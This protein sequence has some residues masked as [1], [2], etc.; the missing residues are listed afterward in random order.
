R[1]LHGYTLTKKTTFREVCYA[2]RDSAFV[3]SDLPA[4][5]SLEVH[6]S[7]EQHETM[8]EIMTEAWK[9]LLVELTPEQ[10]ADLESGNIKQ[11]PSPAELRNKIL[12]KVKWSP[13]PKQA[14][15]LDAQTPGG[16]IEAV[17]ARADDN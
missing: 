8:V 5:V 3:A 16:T 11:L 7:L 2:I 4:I 1:V 6:T 15:S 14:A 17:V 13:P 9:G 10:I 12:I